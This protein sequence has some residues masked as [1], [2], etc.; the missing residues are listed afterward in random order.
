MDIEGSSTRLVPHPDGHQCTDPYPHA[1][2]SCTGFAS[3]AQA[4]LNVARG[5]LEQLRQRLLQVQHDFEHDPSPANSTRLE[6]ARAEYDS[7][8]LQAEQLR[9][10]NEELPI[11]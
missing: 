7:A 5:S 8:V 3:Q 4:Q 2:A 11:E 6:L 1:L 9:G 10:L